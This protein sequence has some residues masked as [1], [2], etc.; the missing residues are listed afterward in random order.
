MKEAETDLCRALTTVTRTPAWT[1]DH[2]APVVSVEGY[3]G[4]IHLTHIDVIVEASAEA[5]VARG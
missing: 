5:A 3:A 1:L 4:G 2:G